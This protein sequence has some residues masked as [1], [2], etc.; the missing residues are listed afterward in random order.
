MKPRLLDLFC[1]A[2]GASRGYQ[3]AGF[4]VTGMDEK[5]FKRYGG[6]EFIQGDVMNVRPG[7]IA[8]NF[9]AVAASPPCQKYSRTNGMWNAKKD[10]PDLV[11]PTREL[12]RMSDLPWIME[13]VVGAPLKDP[14]LLCGTMFGLGVDGAELQRHRLFECSWPILFVPECQHGALAVMGVYGGHVRDRCRVITV[15]GHGPYDTGVGGSQHKSQYADRT[16]VITVVGKMPQQNVDASARVRR[17]FTVDQAREA[18]GIDW[19][20]MSQLSQAIP[21]A[22]TKWLGRELMLELA[23]QRTNGA[24]APVRDSIA[25]VN[26]RLEPFREPL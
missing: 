1:G 4:H 12:L 24:L 19:M 6:N 20:P 3:Q 15:A 9:D 14:V 11:A 2:G 26:E 5:A 21:P 23:Y 8:R 25:P 22:Y 18:M 10:H 17:T 16:G 7:W 13:N